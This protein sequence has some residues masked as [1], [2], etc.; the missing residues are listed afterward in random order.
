MNTEKII[1]NNLLLA[2][3]ARDED[4]QEGLNFISSD[5]DF[6]QVGFW[7]YKKGKRLLSHMHL[8]AKREVLKTQEVIFVKKGSLK[9]DIFTQ[10]GKLYKSIELKKG[11]TGIFLNGG[12]GYEIL[13]EGT[14]VLEVK[15][16]PYVGPEQDRKRI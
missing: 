14:Q 11:D 12:H 15:N 10:E 8:E 4:W 3:I 5:V 13:E 6:V 1:H 16:G 9:A 2:V 7:Y